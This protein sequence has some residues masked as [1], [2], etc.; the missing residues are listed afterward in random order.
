[1]YKYDDG[2]NKGV[3]S[4][5]RKKCYQGFFIFDIWFAS[6]RSHEITMDGCFVIICMVE[7][8]KKLFIKYNIDNLT[9]YWPKGSSLMLN[10]KSVVPR[11]R[12]LTGVGYNYNY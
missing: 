8:N 1:M 10:R 9:N 5:G 3:R 4:E 6:N 7:T 12:P 2:R 11:Y